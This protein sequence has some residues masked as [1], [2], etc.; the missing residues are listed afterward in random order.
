M[1]R[2]CAE[3][4]QRKQADNIKYHVNIYSSHNAPTL[5]PMSRGYSG[6][7]SSADESSRRNSKKGSSRKSKS[8]SSNNSNHALSD[9]ESSP[10]NSSSGWNN[11]SNTNHW[12]FPDE[13]VQN[14]LIILNLLLAFAWLVLYTA[15]S[16]DRAE[17]VDLEKSLG[18]LG[19][20]FTPKPKLCSDNE[21]YG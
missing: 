14:V 6:G 10:R 16:L 15:I 17:Y 13:A 9:R 21:T 12:L 7:H 19:K 3:K 8:S 5:S 11:R 1:C 20:P 4:R 18:F 2:V